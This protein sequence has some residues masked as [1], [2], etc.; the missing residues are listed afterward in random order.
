MALVYKVFD[1]RLERNVAVKIIRIG[2]SP[3]DVLD[4]VL[5]PSSAK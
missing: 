2:V 5:K 3:P 1:T 4:R